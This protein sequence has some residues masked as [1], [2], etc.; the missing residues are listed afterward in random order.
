MVFSSRTYIEA[1][2]SDIS[3]DEHTVLGV[4]E[5]EKGVGA[6]LL[7]LLAVK[8]EDRAVNVVEQLG[9]VLD[10]S[11]TTE[12]DDNLLLLFLHAHQ[13]G[14]EENETLVSVAQDVALLQAVHGTELLLFVDVD[15][16]GTGSQRDSSKI[17]C[18][19]QLVL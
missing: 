16:E 6:L 17:L 1:T 18:K 7:L 2:G 15:I 5:F 4:A 14:E 3:A 11:A 19:K 8:V 13:E 12:E 9:V 10:G